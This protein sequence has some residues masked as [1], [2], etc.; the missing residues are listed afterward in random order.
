MTASMQCQNGTDCAWKLCFEN[1]TP[2]SA[3]NW[4]SKP[5]RNLPVPKVKWETPDDRQ[6]GCSKHVEFYILLT[7]H[8]VMILGK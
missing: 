8:H 5:A 7:V 6:K 3:W 1:L 4:S 2:D